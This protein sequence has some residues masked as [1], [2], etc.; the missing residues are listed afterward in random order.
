VGISLPGNIRAFNMVFAGSVSIA[1]AD[2]GIHARSGDPTDMSRYPF[3]KRRSKCLVSTPA[4]LFGTSE[5]QH[6]S[7][8]D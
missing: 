2:I 8:G 3:Q 6:D 1:E 4:E 5:F 7:L